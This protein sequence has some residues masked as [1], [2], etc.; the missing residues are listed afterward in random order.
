MG[1]ECRKHEILEMVANKLTK[2]TLSGFQLQLCTLKGRKEQSH[3]RAKNTT[4]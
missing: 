2:N 3:S 1:S 4:G